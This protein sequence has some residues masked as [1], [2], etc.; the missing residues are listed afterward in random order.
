MY[1]N[2]AESIDSAPFLIGIRISLCVDV[3]AVEFD[4]GQEVGVVGGDGIAEGFADFLA[5]NLAARDERDVE[6]H[7]RVSRARN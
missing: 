6:N 5:A 1:L 7:V 3:G 2:G 4:Y